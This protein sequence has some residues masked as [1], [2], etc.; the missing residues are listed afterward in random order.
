MKKMLLLF[1]CLMLLVGCGK[2]MTNEETY[3]Y[4][5]R[6]MGCVFGRLSRYDD[7]TYLDISCDDNIKINYHESSDYYQVIW[8]KEKEITCY[9]ANDSNCIGDDGPFKAWLKT[10]KMTRE[11]VLDAIDY[12]VE[13]NKKK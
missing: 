6:D 1:F 9:I 12:Y 7:S 8:E 13:N 4:M 5:K 10:N 3:K 11:Q 2:K